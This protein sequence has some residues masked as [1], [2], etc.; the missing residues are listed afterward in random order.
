VKQS[1]KG[2]SASALRVRRFI[3]GNHTLE[4]LEILQVC[5][6][7]VDIE[8]HPGHWDIEVDAVENL[9]ESRTVEAL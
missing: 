5:I 1:V 6:L 3:E 9:T 7:R 2:L 4:D 8:L